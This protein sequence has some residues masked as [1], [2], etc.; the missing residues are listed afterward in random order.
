MTE[1]EGF[2]EFLLNF[3]DNG[4][5]GKISICVRIPYNNCLKFKNKD[6]V[7]NYNFMVF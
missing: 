7:F 6:I 4:K 2:L 3:I 5:N 1:Q